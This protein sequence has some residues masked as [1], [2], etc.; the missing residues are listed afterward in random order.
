MPYRPN[1]PCKHPGC[2][3]LVAYG[4]KYCDE[5]KPLHP[6]TKRSAASRGYTSKWQ[7]ESKRYLRDNPLCVMCKANGRF[8]EATVVDH[9]VPHRGNQ[10]LFWSHSNWQ[11]LCK[12]CHDKK[13]ERKT[14][15]LH[16]PTESSYCMREGRSKSLQWICTKTAAPLSVH[17]R[18]IKKGGSGKAALKKSQNI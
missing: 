13:Q 18:K 14:V 11:A 12:P 16:I 6:E 7:K 5:H 10:K 8:V 9:I 4:Q 2:G 3:K 17:F 1:I 15:H